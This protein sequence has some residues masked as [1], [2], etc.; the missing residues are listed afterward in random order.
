[1]AS[2]LNATYKCEARLERDRVLSNLCHSVS[3][4]RLKGHPLD[5]DATRALDTWCGVK[6]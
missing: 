3:L 2:L 4:T 5:Q 1:M 6:L